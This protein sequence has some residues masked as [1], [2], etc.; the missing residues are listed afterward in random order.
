MIK[1]KKLTPR[2]V[3]E[4]R[5][6]VIGGSQD[7]NDEFLQRYFD[8]Q[9]EIAE[10]AAK[11]VEK[12]Q[13]EAEKK[14]A[15][16]DAAP[17]DPA[18]NE[19]NT[20]TFKEV[21]INGKITRLPR[22]TWGK[23]TRD[24][25]LW[26][27]IIYHTQLGQEHTSKDYIKEG[28]SDPNAIEKVSCTLQNKQ[29]NYTKLIWAPWYENSDAEAIPYTRPSAM[30]EIAQLFLWPDAKELLHN[31]FFNSRSGTRRSV[32]VHLLFNSTPED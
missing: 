3:C 23:H 10:V 7:E 26:M 25:P 11:E 8:T 32:N 15:T 22:V 28:C 2:Q 24:L 19:N 16:K 21:L 29:G 31:G 20:P 1:D 18:C 4:I 12:A 6:E 14:K 17:K 9:M 30:C 5:K 13:K 27:N